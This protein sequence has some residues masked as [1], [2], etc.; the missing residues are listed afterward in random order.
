MIMKSLKI[1][2]LALAIAAVTFTATAQKNV[3]QAFDAIINCPEAKVTESHSLEKDPNTFVKTGQCDIYCFELP[4]S[5]I[6]LINNALKAFAKDSEKAYAYNRGTS[7]RNSSGITVA[8]GND[9]NSGVKVTRPGHEYVYSL[10]LAPKQEDAEGIYRYAYCMNYKESGSK[11]TGKL[12][13]TY[14]TTLKYRQEHSSRRLR[15]H[16]SPAP[17]KWVESVMG[18]T[19]RLYRVNKKDLKLPVAR[20][21]YSVV[22]SVNR[23]SVSTGDINTAREIIITARDDP[24]NSDRMVQTILN[25]CLEI[26]K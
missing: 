18:Q 6:G 17:E 22:S 8:V 5:K 10:F 14:A 7:I 12:A 20:K 13:V 24:G 21:I 1:K 25:Q 9:R 2:L 16:T 23:D 15:I 3:R 26:L 19:T 4:A 11:I